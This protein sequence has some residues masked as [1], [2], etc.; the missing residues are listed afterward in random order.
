MRRGAD[1]GRAARGARNSVDI[2]PLLPCNRCYARGRK[3][4]SVNGHYGLIY[5]TFAAVF[6][7]IDASDARYVSCATLADCVREDRYNGG[8]ACIEASMNDRACTPVR[9][10]QLSHG[11]G[12][13]CK[14]APAVLREILGAAKGIL[15]DALLVGIE[16]SDDD[17]VYRIDDDRAIV[18]TT[19]FFMPIVDDPFDFGAIAAPRHLKRNAGARAADT[20]ILG[21][22]LGA[23]V[24]GAAL[25]KERL[26][27]ERY[28]V[29]IA[30][31]TQLN[32]A[33]IALGKLDAVHA[34]TDVTAFGLL[35]H[36][37]RNL[38]RVRKRRDRRLRARSAASR[39]DRARTRRL[40]HRRF[41]ARLGELRRRC[42]PRR[43]HRRCGTHD[44]HRSANVRR[45][46]R[47]MSTAGCNRRARGLPSRRLRARC[48][49][50]RIRRRRAARLRPL[51]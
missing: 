19:D 15:P 41:S 4:H 28:D 39:R 25:K 49:D 12:C 5:I 16:T 9:L 21:K 26:S 44:P 30:S 6:G 13:G 38:P 42:R 29:M 22:P 23:G 10:T 27:H 8:Y 47:R 43:A 37:A 20:L 7:A 48:R 2:D 34:L 45:A 11:G 18:A 17:A 32:T 33:S 14:I 50:R 51:T 36:P 46:A 35:G 31:T 24:Y 3:S 40:G 1:A